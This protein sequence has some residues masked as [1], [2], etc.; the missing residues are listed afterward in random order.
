MKQYHIEY[1]DYD[2]DLCGEVWLDTHQEAFQYL[3]SRALD[4]LK[5]MEYDNH[6][7]CTKALVKII[8]DGKV[9]AQKLLTAFNKWLKEGGI[10]VSYQ[11]KLEDQQKFTF[12]PK[13]NL[14]RLAVIKDMW[15]KWDE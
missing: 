2:P 10:Y 7:K 13:Y 5:D 6:S 15:K 11:M 4:E 1:I 12:D 8:E 14:E 3:A 9:D